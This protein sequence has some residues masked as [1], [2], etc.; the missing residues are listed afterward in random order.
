[1]RTGKAVTDNIRQR[2]SILSLDFSPNGDALAVGCADSTVRL[3]DA[4][5]GQPLTEPIKCLPRAAPPRF[6]LD[7]RFLLAGS[8]SAVPKWDV[9]PGG[10]LNPFQGSR[11]A[12]PSFQFSHDG[13]RVA[14]RQ[15]TGEVSVWDFPSGLLVTN[16]SPATEPSG[17]TSYVS[18]GGRWFSPDGRWLAG[19]SGTARR[20][21]V[22]SCVSNWAST[23]PLVFTNQVTELAFG[24][25]GDS[26]LVTTS[27]G[28]ARLRDLRGGQWVSDVVLTPPPSFERPWPRFQLSRDG[29]R[30]LGVGT[31]TVRVWEAKTGRLLAE[32]GQLGQALEEAWFSPDEK[33]IVTCSGGGILDLWDA[34]TGRRSAGPVRYLGTSPQCSPDGRRMVS[35]LPDNTALVWDLRS[36]RAAANPLRHD[37]EVVSTQ[38]SPDDQRVLTWTADGTARVW[39]ANAG[40]PVTEPLK[41]SEGL[42]N[43]QFSPDG[44][45]LVSASWTH[46][47]IWEIPSVS[48]PAPPWLPE[49]AEAIAGKRI[50]SQ[51]VSEPVPISELLRLKRQLAL[52]HATDTCTL[53]AQWFLADRSTRAISPSLDLTFEQYVRLLVDRNTVDS[54]AEAVRLSPANPAALALLARMKLNDTFNQTNALREADFLSRRA[55]ELGPD[56]AEAWRWR[57]RVLLAFAQATNLC[58]ADERQLRTANAFQAIERAVEF[59]STNTGIWRTYQYMLQSGGDCARA[60]GMIEAAAQRAPQDGELRQLR[61][62]LKGMALEATNQLE[63]ARSAYGDGLSITVAG[64]DPNAATTRQTLLLRRSNLLRRL[65]RRT[66]SNADYAQW[67]EAAFTGAQECNVQ[68]WAMVTGPT[69]E[70]D[71]ERGLLLAQRA[72]RLAPGDGTILNTLGVACYRAGNFNKAVETLLECVRLN[73][74]AHTY[75]PDADYF[76]LALA[77]HQLGDQA[78]AQSYYQMA[79]EAFDKSADHHDTELMRDEA[80]QVLGPAPKAGRQ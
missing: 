3:L 21:Q 62:L 72:V 12:G 75:S 57:G 1:M 7:G 6:S 47:G 26:L 79:L 59:S 58:A 80:L 60:L 66:E 16:L 45:W 33:S 64:G 61:C 30:V 15:Y 4:L 28:R 34:S 38:F 20:V 67:A 48:P 10:A 74:T 8:I 54:V 42:G 29:L 69:A 49:L 41:H 51:G 22:W 23:E 9:R 31:R 17:A 77:Y 52:S 36:G 68:A 73:A 19:T 14:V 78:K 70:R 40:Q 46:F 44:R 37:A 63:E 56:L 13:Q 11:S 24:A 2:A 35:I 50:N 18:L 71:A 76:V 53:W 55:V 65:G 39:D 32:T 25:D 27:D 43:A 5:T